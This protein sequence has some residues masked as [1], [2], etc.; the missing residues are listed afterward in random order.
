MALRA[1]IYPGLGNQSGEPWP[2]GLFIGVTDSGHP[3]TGL[4]FGLPVGLGHEF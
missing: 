3:A 4:Q 2:L 1:N